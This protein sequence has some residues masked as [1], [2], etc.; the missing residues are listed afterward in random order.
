MPVRQSTLLARYWVPPQEIETRS[1]EIIDALIATD[2]YSRDELQVVKR[3]VHTTGDPDIIESLHLQP[4]AIAFGVAAIRAGKTLYTDVKMASSGV[5]RSLAS[6]F[7]CQVVCLIEQPDV[8]ADAKRRAITR[9][10]AAVQSQASKMDGSI[11]AIGNAPT[12]LLALLD[13]VDAGVCRP[14]LVVGVPVGF[15]GAAESKAELAGRDLPYITIKGT[16][17]GSTIAAAIL[18]ALL[19]LAAEGMPD[20]SI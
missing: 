19:I 9:A 2:A 3:V 14:A 15:V 10:A 16:R 4:G 12:A 17:G 8:A 6:L 1:F 18:N 13:L 5:N 11:V 20:A 7:G